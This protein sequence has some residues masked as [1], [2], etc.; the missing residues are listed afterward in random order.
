MQESALVRKLS[1][2]F[3]E[4]ALQIREIFGKIFVR[5]MDILER[6]AS[7]LTVFDHLNA[8]CFICTTI[9]LISLSKSCKKIRK[10]VLKFR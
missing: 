3:N 8:V 10:T 2:L 7:P 1:L 5:I 4:S 6:H 9:E